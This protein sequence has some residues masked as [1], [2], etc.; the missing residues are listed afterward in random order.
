LIIVSA[1]IIS[2]CEALSGPGGL[3]D[4]DAALSVSRANVEATHHIT[5]VA[6][7]IAVNDDLAGTY[8]L[9]ADLV[10]SDWIPIG[11]DQR[12]LPTIVNPFTGTFDGQGHTITV[13][14]FDSTVAAGGQYLGIFAVIGN[15]TAYFPPVSVSNLTVALGINPTTASAQYVGG[16]AGYTD[17]A[18]FNTLSV[19]GR[20]DVTQSP[21]ATTFNVGGVAGFA[22]NSSF[23]NVKEDL[24]GNAVRAVAPVSPVKWEIWQGD[25]IFRARALIDSVAAVTGQDGVTIGGTAGY[26]RNSLFSNVTVSGRVNATGQTQGTPVYVGGVVGAAIGTNIDDS[27]TSAEISGEGPGY[28]TSAGGV[29]GYITGSRVRNSYAVGRVNLRGTSVDFGYSYSWQVYAGGLVGYAGGS[30]AGPSLVYHSY[31]TGEVYAFAPYPYA[32]GLVGYLYGYNDFVNPAKNGSTVSRSYAI[33]IVRAETQT[34]TA[35][36]IADIPYAGGLVGYSSV[37]DS[38]IVDSYA[39]GDAYAVTKGTYAWAGGI[40]GGNANNAVVLRT[41]ATGYVESVTGDLPSLYPPAYADAGPAAG[42][43]AGFNY[44]TAATSVS[45]SVALNDEV[46]GTNGAARQAVVHRVVGSLGS[47]AGIGTLNTNYAFIEMIVSEFWAQ[48]IGLDRVDGAN[49]VAVP[50]QSLYENTLHWDFVDV[51]Q[52]T[53]TYPTL[54]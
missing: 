32:G 38:T 47:G 46:Y 14:S 3:A 31:A 40:V 27:W 42:G 53:G 36:N 22:D 50:P 23:I 15:G 26:A 41:Y 34:D 54:R 11:Y 21:A 6:D 5:S 18:T 24:N 9:D 20:L 37:A 10:V 44:Y 28:N 33:G 51:W 39:T 12:V 4:G 35:H 16:L 45:R 1:L 43:I 17:T 25:G 29:A 49:T 2:S 30:N 7:L 48:D 8:L 19:T 52:L 13:N